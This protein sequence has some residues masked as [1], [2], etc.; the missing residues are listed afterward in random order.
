MQTQFTEEVEKIRV[1]DRDHMSNIIATVRYVLRCNHQGQPMM[2][3][4]DVELPDPDPG[5]FV[6]FDQL[7]K[8][9]VLTWVQDKVGEEYIQERKQA[10]M[11]M[12]EE[13][14]QA[15]QPQPRE[16]GAPW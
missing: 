5:K 6:D 8:S 10:M 11:D 3:M 9:Q 1:I 4:W 2:N 7:T 13:M 12:A 14:L 15:Q 16:V